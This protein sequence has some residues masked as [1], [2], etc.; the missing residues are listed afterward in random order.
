[1]LFKKL[2]ITVLCLWLM[3]IISVSAQDFDPPLRLEFDMVETKFPI[4]MELLGKNGLVLFFQKESKED[5]KWIVCQYDT[6]F[7][8][9]KMRAVPFE[10]KTIVCATGS[11]ENFFYAMLQNEVNTKANTANTYILRYDATTKKIDV[12]SFY[13]AE[14]GKIT[15]IVHFGNIFVYSVYNSKSEEHVYVFNTKSLE[16]A[17]L[18]QN[19]VAPHEFQDTYLDTIS[20][21]LW[22]VS[23]FY[24]AKKQTSI[25]LMQLDTNGSVLQ[26]IP[27][28]LDG[29]KYSINSCKIVYS[30]KENSLLLVGNYLDN[31]ENR[32]STRSNNSGVFTVTVKNG[33]VGQM[34]FF[35][36]SSFENWYAISKKTFSNCYD[37]LYFVTQNDSLVIL[38]S[39][40]YAPEYQQ[41]YTSQYAGSGFY[42][43]PSVESK[44]IGFKYQNACIFTFDKEG[45]LLWHNPLNYSELILK[46]VHPLLNG[47]IDSETNDALFL[48]GFNNKIFSLI[49]N[50]TLMVQTI[51]SI[52][53]QSSS[54][55]ES[56]NSSE[57]V[58]C[59]HWYDN[60]FI[61]SAYQRTSK[62]Y[63]SNTRKNNK[64]VFGVNKLGYM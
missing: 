32:H 42:P 62:K 64:Y 63:S 46:S 31:E 24:E 29:S 28:T 58:N 1:M 30:D 41:Y 50:K 51:K 61:Y 40:F 17:I 3:P 11:D 20:Q 47:Y 43:S 4:N 36:Y 15:S 55:F 7:Q 13:L 59:Q 33:Q 57:K 9:Q 27:F 16:H 25:R 45:K 35:D 37:I 12:F 6:I 53:V 18:H 10:T 23:K 48:F 54:R 26:E 38:A 52:A 22:L 19:K 56:I 14:K 2:I 44:L 5:T 34:H 60:Y 39:D 8:I 21:R 49:C